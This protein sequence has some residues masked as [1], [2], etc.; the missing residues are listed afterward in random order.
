MAQAA[1]KLEQA[2]PSNISGTRVA[3]REETTSDVE[4]V[5]SLAP[6]SDYSDSPP[7]LLIRGIFFAAL[8]MVLFWAGVV[9]ALS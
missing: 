8:P 4:V 5:G 6:C 7:E 3:V 2:L 9:Y 1:H